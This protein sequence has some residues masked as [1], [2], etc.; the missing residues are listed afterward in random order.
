MKINAREMITPSLSRDA[1][2]IS[3]LTIS[4]AAGVRPPALWSNI[5]GVGWILACCL[6]PHW[7]ELCGALL[8]TLY[9]S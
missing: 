7:F 8:F 9:G 1:L 6:P 5:G 2:A 3:S 4:M